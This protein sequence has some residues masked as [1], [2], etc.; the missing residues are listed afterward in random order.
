MRY[1]EKIIAILTAPE[2]KITK[3]FSNKRVVY[4]ATHGKNRTRKKNQNRIYKELL[5]CD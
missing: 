1:R 2:D 3:A 5:K 4:L